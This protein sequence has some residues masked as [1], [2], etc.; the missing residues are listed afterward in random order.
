MRI[1]CAKCGAPC[2]LPAPPTDSPLRAGTAPPRLYEARVVGAHD[3]TDLAVLKI[4][5]KGLPALRLATQT[6]LRE[7]QI[8]FA[9]GSPEG[10][11]STATMGV[12]SSVARQADFS[13][14]MLFIQT[15]APINPGNSGGPLVNTAGEVVGINTFIF[16]QSGGSQGLGF[17]IPAG[18]VEFVYQ[19]LRATGRVDRVEIGVSVRSITP[20]LAAGLGLPVDYGV[21]VQDVSPD[22][23][24]ARAGVQPD[25]VIEAVDG[26][27]IHS[28]P[29]L[30]TALYQHRPGEPVRVR[31]RRDGG[32]RD[33][34][35]TGAAGH[36][37]DQLA[38]LGDPAKNLVPR[39]GIVGV[40]IDDRLRAAIGGL[41]APTGV[42]V[43]ALTAD[44]SASDTG[45]QVGDVI[46][47][48]NRIPV[49]SLDDLRAAL[50]PLGE[51]AP[52]V[53]RIERQRTLQYLDFE[54]ESDRPR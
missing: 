54:L 18:V 5:A 19:S 13:I 53:L 3:E 39:L 36:P 11:A 16:T 15:D 47:E 44:P 10:L 17:A 26:R 8:V 14:P 12:I 35:I 42:I 45:L 46:H 40:T 29:A 49:Q 50:A 48:L 32:T 38:S 21:L 28:L 4:E 51:G 43:A 7:G 31:I 41:R 27:P 6:A 25:D 30:A 1:Y 37:H 22:G 24:A 34:S 20:P 52:V 2:E 9:I 33:L 23:P